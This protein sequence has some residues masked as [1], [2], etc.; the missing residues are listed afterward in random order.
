MYID[1][2]SHIYLDAF[3][4]D[5]GDMLQRAS[6][7]GVSLVLMPAID[8]GT[9]DTMLQIEAVHPQACLSMMGLHPCSVAENLQ[10]ELA[11][12]KDY[13]QKRKFVAIGETGLDFHWDLTYKELQYQAFE[14]QIE[15]ALEY[16]LPVVVHSRKSTEACVEV[17]KKY[18]PKGLKGVFHCFSGD[19]KLAR[20]VLDQGFYLGIGGVATF[21]N[22]GLA[23]ILPYIPM[24]SLLLETDAPYLAPVPYRG[25]R[26]EPAYIPIIA[27]KLAALKN[28]SV[29]EIGRATT[30]NSQK[31][32]NLTT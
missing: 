8:S 27:E 30:I 7:A 15:W 23:E 24:E 18:A 6:Q 13:L 28:L 2:H 20:A 19:L 5:M 22:G 3:K 25:K 12:V 32:F 17:I 26:N 31:L 21:K 11:I 4:N 1:S 16:N 9:H 29:E 10:Q 14:Q